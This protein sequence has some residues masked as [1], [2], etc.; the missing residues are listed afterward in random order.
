MNEDYKKLYDAV[1]AKFDIGDYDSFSAK[2]QTPEDRKKFYDAV[3]S[4]GLDLGDYNEYESRLKKKEPTTTE[5]EQ[6]L[7]Q[8]LEPSQE[9]GGGFKI[10]E[11]QYD[12]T[13]DTREKGKP[14]IPDL[15]KSVEEAPI[16]EAV[17]VE[18]TGVD[19]LQSIEQEQD[20]LSQK[21]NELNLAFNNA[22]KPEEKQD[23]A[24]QYKETVGAL[25]Q[26]YKDKQLALAE[27]NTFI[28]KDG[29]YVNM[30]SAVEAA[31]KNKYAFNVIPRLDATEKKPEVADKFY[32]PLDIIE[33]KKASIKELNDKISEVKNDR[34]NQFHYASLREEL[35]PILKEKASVLKSIEQAEINNEDILM[36]EYGAKY[37]IDGK[38]VAKSDF[39]NYILSPDGSSR[40]K[41]NSLDISIENDPGMEDL[42]DIQFEGAEM[43]F[44]EESSRGFAARTKSIV[45]DGIAI[46]YSEVFMQIADL[47]A[48]TISAEDA[49]EAMGKAIVGDKDGYKITT[50]PIVKKAIKMA[51]ESDN[52]NFKD[53]FLQSY[54]SI[55]RDQT[56]SI[57]G[58]RMI[59]NYDAIDLLV[60]GRLGDFALEVTKMTIESLPYMGAAMTGVG[61]AVMFNSLQANN[62]YELR[63]Q[64]VSKV[65][66]FIAS[67]INA[68]INTYAE[69]VGASLFK[70]NINLAKSITE[71]SAKLAG[72]STEATKKLVT[73]VLETYRKEVGVEILQGSSEYIVNQIAKGEEV[74]LGKAARQGGLEALSAFQTSTVAS[75]PS[76]AKLVY[77]PFKKTIELSKMNNVAEE[78]FSKIITT[79]NSKDRQVL[80]KELSSIINS[81]NDRS[82]EVMAVAEKASPK[83]SKKLKDITVAQLTIE[84]AMDTDISKE[85]K[86]ALQEKMDQLEKEKEAILKN[87][88]EP[89]KQPGATKKFEGSIDPEKS[90]NFSNLT[91][92]DN[93]D[94]IF[95]HVSDAEIEETDPSLIGTAKHRATSNDEARELA[96]VGGVTMFY[97]SETDGEQ[98]VPGKN[99]YMFKVDKDKVYD[100]N[101][102]P[103]NFAKKAQERHEKENPGK[104]YNQNTQLAYVTKIANENGFEVVVSKWNGKSRAQSTIPM[105]PFDVQRG[106]GNNI[107]ENFEKSYTANNKKGWKSS[108][109]VTK[110][111]T[112]DVVYK[113]IYDIFNKAKDYSSKL[114]SLSKVT[115]Y[116][117]D[118][119]NSFVPFKNQDEITAEI[120]AS[121]IPEELKQEYRDALKTEDTPGRSSREFNDNPTTE[122]VTIENAPDGTYVN[123]GLT[124]G[125]GTEAVSKEEVK[126]ALPKDVKILEESEIGISEGLVN[127]PTLSLKLSRPLTSKEILDLRNA[128]SQKAIPQLSNGEGIMYGTLDWGPF[129]SEFFILPNKIKLSENEKATKGNRLFNKPLKA[130]KEIANRYYKRIFGGR[131][132]EFF[133][134]KKIDKKFAK[135]ISDAYEA[136][137][138]DPNNPEVKAAYDALIKETLDQYQDIIDAGYVIEINNNEPYNNSQDMITDLEKNKTIKILSTESEFGGKKITNKQREENPMLAETK[139]KDKNGLPLLANDIFRAVHDF[140]GHAELGNGFGPLG[141]ENAWNVHA[142]MYSPLARRAMTTETRGQNSWVNFSGINDEAFKK[143]DRARQLRREGKEEEAKALAEEV[144]NE[145]IF[146]EQKVGLLPE[147]FSELSD[148]DFDEQEVKDLETLTK[149]KR[150]S[151]YTKPSLN[152]KLKEEAVKAMNEMD[153]AQVNFKEPKGG[154]KKTNP[155]VNIGKII[156]KYFGKPVKSLVMKVEDFQGI[157]MFLGMS[158]IL[159]AGTV[160]DSSGKDMNVNGGLLF[161]L[162][163]GNNNL[164]WAGVNKK[165][166]EDHLKRAMYLYESHKAL[167]D[168]LWKEGKLPDGHIPMAIMRMSD[169][170]VL[171]NEAF[172]RYSLNLIKSAS[173]EKNVKSLQV[174]IDAAKIR[175]ETLAKKESLNKS[176]KDELQSL[177]RVIDLGPKV[178]TMS[179]LFEYIINDAKKNEDS[180]WS[181]ALKASLAKKLFGSTSNKGEKNSRPWVIEL[182]GE[183]SSEL[184]LNNIYKGIGDESVIDVD[185]GYILGIMGVDVKNNPG[186]SQANHDNYGWGANGRIIALFENL[187]DGMDV[188]PEFFAKASRVFTQSSR[189]KIPN[190]TSI[191][192]QVRG[193]AFIDKAFVGVRI[194]TKMSNI[195]IISGKIRYAFPNVQVASTQA[196]FDEIMSTEGVREKR[197]PDGN[198]IA[199]ITINGKIYINPSVANLSTPIHEFGHI[200]MDYLRSE[201]SGSKGTALYKKGMSLV[202]G[203][204]ELEK[205]KE[206]YPEYTLEQQKEE[207]LV[208]LIATRGASIIEAGKN[209]S[210]ISWLNAVYEYV[211]SKL[212]KSKDLSIR[213]IKSLSLEKFADIA[214]ADLFG[215]E[216]INAKFN[217]QMA[218]YAMESRFS[219]K[220]TADMSMYSIIKEA[221]L[222]NFSD[223]AIKEF[224]RREG[225]AAKDI[226]SALEVPKSLMKSVPQSFG[227][228]EGGMIKGIELYD[229]IAK[230]LARSK[231]LKEMRQKAQDLLYSTDE[232]KKASDNLKKQMAYDL[233]KSLATSEN[234]EVAK[235]MRDIR[236]EL[237]SRKRGAKELQF[238][239][240]KLRTFIRKNIPQS[241]YEKKE[242]MDLISAVTNATPENIQAIVKD[243]N[244]LVVKHGVKTARN[245]IAKALN[246]KLNK[247]ESGR[248][249]GKILP[250]DQD[251]ISG[252]ISNMLTEEAT[253][254]DIE[255]MSE[256]LRK[257]YN[258][259]DSKNNLNQREYEEMILIDL[260]LNYNNSLL[261]EDNDVLKLQSLEYVSSS[262]E[263]IKTGARMRMKFALT[264]Q[265]EYYNQIKNEFFKDVT[266]L[267]IDFNNDQ[268]VLNS[269]QKIRD[270][271]AKV[272]NR[273]RFKKFVENFFSPVSN[274]V[275]RIEGMEGLL[276]KV[277]RMAGEMFEGKSIELILDRIDDANIEFKMGRN[278]IMKTLDAKAQEI[279]GSNHRK[280]MIKNSKPT[281][282][283]YSNPQKVQDLVDK[284]TQETD[285]KEKKKIEKEIDSYKMPI[286]QNEMYYIYNQAKDKSNHPGF[287]STFGPQ[288]ESIIEHITNKLGPKVKEWADWQVD[289]FFPSVYE[290]YNAVY[291]EIYRTDMPWNAMYAGRIHREGD[292]D[293]VNLLENTNQYQTSVGG[294]ST[295]VRIKNK[296]KIRVVDGDSNLNSYINEMEFFAHYSEPMRDITKM[297]SNPDIKDGIIATTGE[298]AYKVLKGQLDKVMNRNSAKGTDIKI[299]NFLSNAFVKAK[300]GLSPV[301]FLKQT[302][303]AIAFADYIG[304]RDWAKN[305]LSNNLASNWSEL[306]ANSVYL[307]DRYEQSDISKVLENY[308]AK[309]EVSFLDN[310]QADKVN[311]FLMYMIKQ[312]DKMGVM[313]SIPNYI[314]YKENFMARGMD[315]Q[316][317]IKEAVKKVE[318]QIKTTQQSN[319]IQDKDFFQTSEPLYRML[320]LFMSSPRALMRKEIIATRNLYRKMTGQ[321]SK[322]SVKDNLR[323]FFT[324]HVAIPLFFQYVSLGFP[325]LLRNWRDDD[326]DDLIW[327][328][329]LGNINAVFALGDIAVA[330]KDVAT[331]KP[332]AGG[333]SQ[334]PFFQSAQDII[335]NY[336]RFSNASKDET[337]N[338]Y[339]SKMI[340]GILEPAS[341]IPVANIAKFGENY[342]KLATGDVDDFGEALLRLFNY[343]E[344]AI[345]GPKV[346]DTKSTST[347]RTTSRSTSR[348]TRQTTR[349]SRTR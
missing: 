273:P 35:D 53:A 198:L 87:I 93:G 290:K 46:R 307:Q 78:L 285:P 282:F 270:R 222:N 103:L 131:R 156:K 118:F 141:E 235:E 71:N 59:K 220:R 145:M 324:Y 322:G 233:D 218:Q 159:A 217:P 150:K 171:S 58:N 219:K 106:D 32:T 190:M 3:S 148:N 230:G 21:V 155:L 306:Y 191:P 309:N 112:L 260:A 62:Y 68:F 224:L 201:E 123:I 249:K 253:P 135:R 39:L 166:A 172:F 275:T 18:P 267:D 126:N 336:K 257:R 164:A 256:R 200:W 296:K 238:I 188:F 104:T 231:S 276:D 83:Q 66:A 47:F 228:I 244:D 266:G 149:T 138:H 73:K 80:T 271:Q 272:D 323:T 195:D 316:S 120:E 90:E 242:V 203:T 4:K 136:M 226:L 142:R 48:S 205:A 125:T 99:K 9:S 105:T 81:I 137:K 340:I 162:T 344:Y 310:V 348:S 181:L 240:A 130:V 45:Y 77:A 124:K 94:F 175:V 91:E 75:S 116:G 263:D 54:A 95:Y 143:R 176:E 346:K 102:D 82:D 287:E 343:S 234:K 303:S 129:N 113:K 225:Y 292:A 89:V 236:A 202:D 50:D 278:A 211:K 110:K 157:P 161:G 140:F 301:I 44:I 332:W 74:D 349:S 79:E 37:K 174:F 274:I 101:S 30:A 314:Y 115:D 184:Y 26:L 245:R 243:V 60:E 69:K 212:V 11:A 299:L 262:I 337:K 325:G 268:S 127:E 227:L 239:K 178:K 51:K 1:S 339:F 328:M 320:N 36:A 41:D 305:L 250:E 255:N 23:I 313:G 151:K 146:A 153:E 185:P 179:G 122:P 288:Y 221:R 14:Q 330:I 335:D 280:I 100:F 237:M 19:K 223:G 52:P 277:S 295:K 189:G 321:Q 333:M 315:E 209:S 311:N 204:I 329:I 76:L 13:T 331:N 72:Y 210:F 187:A 170:A 281:E 215:G 206:L 55:I 61:T 214:L 259:L 8:P 24:D 183:P 289:V 308:T 297:I 294:A 319:D 38:P 165:G 12:L 186:V 64:G 57:R 338:K 168:R 283:Y 258:E 6:P 196:E 20:A 132:E 264:E 326:K 208:E 194:S 10:E 43:G 261:M 173:K 139:Y 177:S 182:F 193:N 154:G 300:L 265:K 98:Q 207:A 63:E 347:S 291:R 117:H 17:P 246:V 134:T 96:K 40:F 114:Y 65:R 160:K 345:K 192:A 152:Q 121:N 107:T 33:E 86:D 286:S 109:P 317:A 56:D 216:E 67:N 229:R 298:D 128:T 180:T 108:E 119:E 147:E 213:N 85:A 34:Y 279:F 252:L 284:L 199:G 144:Y 318:R 16:E 158:D 84:G 22:E 302:T 163:K 28:N 304:Y 49:A 197:D 31:I 133:G 42:V 254:E 88:N 15:R 111:K 92:D 327:A 269:R 7:E 25:N 97:T 232:Y 341:G 248:L 293:Q 70:S 2:M 241:L 5:Q 27:D 342:S 169:T 167:F 312:G 334:I 29:Q 247:L 251:L